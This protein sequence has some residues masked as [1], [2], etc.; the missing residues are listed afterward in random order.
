[1]TKNSDAHN[2]LLHAIADALGVPVEM[3]FDAPQKAAS[4]DVIALLQAWTAIGDAQGQ[5]RV[6]SFA[7]HEA[8]RASGGG[9][10]E[11]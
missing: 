8:E 3:F 6:L 11:A 1:M 9:G 4:E 10:S 2:P 5:R 7:Q